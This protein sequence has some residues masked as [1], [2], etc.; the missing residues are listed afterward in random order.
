MRRVIDLSQSLAGDAS[1]GLKGLIDGC[2]FI[3][4]ANPGRRAL[5][6]HLTP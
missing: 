3:P 5:G 1:Y 4:M 2:L 6:M